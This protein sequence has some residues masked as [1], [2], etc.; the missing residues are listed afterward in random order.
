MKEK[1]G[2]PRFDDP[3]ESY[4]ARLIQATSLILLVA[5]LALLAN[6]LQM[7]RPLAVLCSALAVSFA[8]AALYLLYRRRTRTASFLLPIGFLIAL[9]VDVATAYGLHDIAMVGY[10]TVIVLAGLLLGVRALF[11]FGF[12]AVGALTIIYLLETHGY[13]PDAFAGAT[14][15]GDLINIAVILMITTALLR[16]LVRN[17]YESLSLSRRQAEEQDR[18]I[19]E[20]EAKNSELERFAYTVSHDLKTPLVTISN[21]V[22]YLIDSAERGNLDRLRQDV[23]R[24]TGATGKMSELLDG[25]LELSRAGFVIGPPSAVP[26]E[27]IAREA[28]SRAAGRVES[29]GVKVTVA[30]DL[31]VV[32]ADRERLVEV[33]R[34]LIENAVKFLGEQPHPAIEVGARNGERGPVLFV[35]DNGIGIQPDY[36]GRVLEPFHKLDPASDGAGVGLALTKRILEAHRGEIW[37]ESRGAETGTVICFWLPPAPT[38]DVR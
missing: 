20:L 30:P 16:L 38:R 29:R 32:F 9:S 25:V 14:D 31:P 1:L 33:V 34:N 37:I 15:L 36:H 24:I 8:A 22:G 26:F 6:S 28:L 7:G 10:P 2:L 11:V 19:F 4:T 3:E 18:L 35:R 27:E 23:R 13:V 17:L 21:F 12:A 5:A